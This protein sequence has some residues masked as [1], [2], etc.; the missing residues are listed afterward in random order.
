[1][2]SAVLVATKG[3][4]PEHWAERIRPL[5]PDRT[6][7]RTDREGVFGGSDGELA[8]VEYILAWKPRL[9]TLDRL[10]NLRVIFSLG[11]GVDHVFALPRLPDLP[12]VR[13]VDEDLT[14]RMV[15]YVVWQVLHHLRRGSA[16]WQRQ[17]EHRWEALDQPAA[18]Q[19]TVGIMGLGEMGANSAGALRRLGFPVRGWSR[20][21]KRLEGVEAF[22]GA[23]GFEAFLGGTDILVALLPLT[24]ETTGLIDMGCLSKLR[25][26]GPLGGPILINAG[27]G[28]SQVETDIAAAIRDGT[29]AG[30]SLDV[31]ETE[32]LATNSPLW[33]LPNV[34][35]T[36]H[37]AAVSD[38]HA[39]ARQIAE[40]ILAF[41]RG[42]ALRNVVDRSRGY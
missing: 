28:G 17:A 14:G 37:V 25:R 20:T 7:L 13:I 36:P 23:D 12:I 15:E 22:S 26:S 31:F 38:P 33:D 1:M 5:L 24:P 39:L 40:Q 3:W 27:R 18:H 6:I 19:V 29:L 11:A 32:P 16:Y 8:N 4:E 34:V 10:P 21:P 42:E 35:I 30:A 2:K 41:E 9:E